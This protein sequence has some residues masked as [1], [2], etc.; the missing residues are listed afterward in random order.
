MR[1]KM[2]LTPIVVFLAGIIGAFLRNKEVNTI[3]DPETGLAERFAAVSVLLIVLTAAVI[4]ISVLY[5]ILAEKKGAFSVD[6]QRP[7]PIRSKLTVTVLTIIGVVVILGSVYNYLIDYNETVIFRAGFAILGI[8]TGAAIISDAS[9]AFKSDERKM[10]FLMCIATLFMCWWLIMTYKEN[11]SNP[12]LL[13]Y[14]YECL[15][16]IAATLSFYYA[17]GSIY[18]KILPKRTVVTHLLGIY[19]CM[20]TAVNAGNI[21]QGAIFA[22]L[23]VYQLIRV[24]AYVRG[25]S[26]KDNKEIQ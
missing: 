6:A 8:F 10:G 18:G 3:F 15:G 24:C 22:A 21:A 13:E 17:T 12:V 2:I 26:D 4:L 9:A 23:A 1:K 25:T 5:S 16:I 14:C 19:F 7:F 20:V 11:N